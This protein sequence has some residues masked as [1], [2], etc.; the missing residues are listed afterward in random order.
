MDSSSASFIIVGGRVGAKR[1][2][3]STVRPI[4]SCCA[5]SFGFFADY[6]GCPPAPLLPLPR[7][8]QTAP[9]S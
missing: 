1:L 7:R 6:W 9:S 8:D 5:R 2:D 4:V 3:S